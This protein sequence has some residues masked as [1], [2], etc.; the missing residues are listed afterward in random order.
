MEDRENT[1]EAAGENALP[2]EEAF[3]RLDEVLGEMESGEHSLE[4][5]FSLYEKGLKLVRRCQEAVD[6]IE[7][8]LIILETKEEAGDGQ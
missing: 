5:T 3:R 6:G 8:K 7:K 4:E 1:R 2:L